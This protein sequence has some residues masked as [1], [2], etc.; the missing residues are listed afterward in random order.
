MSR[1][2]HGRVHGKTIVLEED[3]GMPEGQEVEVTLKRVPAKEAWG[4]G[5]QRCA[6]ALADEWTEEDD[7]ILAEIHQ[8]RQQD[9]RRELPE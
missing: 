4:E 1:M 2:I 7:C 8:S 9:S 3:T 6:G 5:L